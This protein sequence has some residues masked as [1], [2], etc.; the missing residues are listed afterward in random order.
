MPKF[1]KLIWLGAGRANKNICFEDF[2]E[3]YLIEA[4]S[5][6]CEDLMLR[7]S[8]NENVKV[9]EEVVSL[10]DSFVDFYEYSLPEFSTFS[11]FSS[12][13]TLFPSMKIVKV[14]NRRTKSFKEILSNIDLGG[15]DNY[16]ICD[17]IDYDFNLNLLDI[18]KKEKKLDL[19]KKI[20][21]CSVSSEV[22]SDLSSADN[23]TS[24]M[25]ENGFLFGSNCEAE[26][27][28]SSLSFFTNPI[29]KDYIKKNKMVSDFEIKIDYLNKNCDELKLVCQ[30][31]EEEKK[32][33]KNDLVRYK[34]EL[35]EVKRHLK[36]R[37]EKISELENSNRK[38]QG[39]NVQLLKK[40][41]V[42][43][44]EMIK[45]EAQIEI[46]KDLLTK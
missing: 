31:L 15:G 19:F 30:T 14:E 13:K 11:D 5:V 25:L 24:Y 6:A 32:S 7:F 9:I 2:E 45:A 21:V 46:I 44:L 37:M 33:I 29:Y 12:F 17:F 18:I 35:G 20:D 23:V 10:S 1:N 27:G 8:N 42:I 40:Q 4:R 26:L 36:K 43:E 3:V 28:F 38:L 41:E 22:Y 34:N 39:E 16:L